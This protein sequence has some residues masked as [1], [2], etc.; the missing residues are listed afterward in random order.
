MSE[1]TKTHIVDC[2]AEM[3]DNG[4]FDTDT[5]WTKGANWTIS[6]GHATRSLQ[7]IGSS[8]EQ[9]VTFV[10]GKKY[11][12]KYEVTDSYTAN[13]KIQGSFGDQGVSSVIG[14]HVYTFTC[15]NTT[16]KLSFYLEPNGSIIIDNVSVLPENV[17]LTIKESVDTF[18]A[19]GG[20][21]II[22][23][24]QYTIDDSGNKTT[25]DIPDNCSIIGNGNVEIIVT[26]NVPLF[27][28][29]GFGTYPRSR[30]TLS[31]MKIYIN[32]LNG[33][34][35]NNVIHFMGVS[36]CIIEKLHITANNG[37]V[38]SSYSAIKIEGFYLAQDFPC[39]GSVITQCIIGQSE[40]N[41]Q[42]THG[43]YLR[44]YNASYPDCINNMITNNIVYSCANGIILEYA[45]FSIVQGNSVLKAPSYGMLILRSDYNAIN[46][47]ITSKNVT[48]GIIINKSSSCAITGNT[49]ID[50]YGSGIHVYGEVLESLK[51]KYNTICGNSIYLSYPNGVRHGIY[52]T[53]YF[54]YNNICGNTCVLDSNNPDLPAVGI[55][56]GPPSQYSE[57]NLFV[58]NVCKAKIP[59]KIGDG[60]NS[61]EANNKKCAI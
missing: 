31:G 22:E 45:P 55:E 46:G 48:D 7:I 59:L 51:A 27:R 19:D 13:F 12:I 17:F 14:V 15:A 52:L 5:I 54:K 30:I 6:G 40:I 34:Y 32:K 23:A 56:E 29:T 39:S 50:D 8:L 43:I 3:V 44:G 47:N 41:N 58:E 49:C 33:T 28:N 21:V 57:N 61:I 36:N 1:F 4:E 60:T 20:N 25:I 42:F 16:N 37:G 10:Q 53:W 24:G 18:G 11:T 38:A 2:D 35:Q 9:T 26:A